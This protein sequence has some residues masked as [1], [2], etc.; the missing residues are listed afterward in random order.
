MEIMCFYVVFWQYSGIIPNVLP[1][2]DA[3]N[4]TDVLRVIDRG[5]VCI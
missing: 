1:T 5:K 2:I 4:R 3:T